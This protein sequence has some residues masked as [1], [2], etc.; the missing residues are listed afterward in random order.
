MSEANGEETNPV[1]RLV[2]TGVALL[3][4]RR[5][6]NRISSKV[7]SVLV[8]TGREDDEFDLKAK[9][10]RYVA[11]NDTLKEQVKDYKLVAWHF[12]TQT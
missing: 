7:F 6:G 11:S 5:I 4:E 10:E 2:I 9:A 1:E 12:A 8:N 3:Y